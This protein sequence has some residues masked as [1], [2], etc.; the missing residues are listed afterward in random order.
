MPNVVTPGDIAKCRPAG[1][2]SISNTTRPRDVYQPIMFTESHMRFENEEINGRLLGDSGYANEPYLLTPLLNP[3]T[4]AERRYNQAHVRTRSVVERLFGIWKRR[5]PCL[6][7]GIRTKLQ[8][9]L[10]VILATAV[11]N[12]IARL[13]NEPDVYQDDDGE[14]D[15]D[16]DDNDDN[17]DDDVDVPGE[18][19]RRYRQG[20]AVRRSIIENHFT[21]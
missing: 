8:A 5:F 10:Q 15:D 11:L 3:A 12:E 4:R 20:H 16:D 19:N 13:L 18:R 14:D 1:A 21:N 17:D 2:G 7:H 6:K 9:A